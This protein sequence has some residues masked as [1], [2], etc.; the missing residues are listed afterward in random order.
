LRDGGFYT[1]WD[2]PLE[3]AE[4][5]VAAMD[6]AG[7]AVIE[8]GYRSP[9]SAGYAG[10]FKY[11]SEELARRLG[12][13][14]D[15]GFAVMV[16][17]KDFVGKEV[18]ISRLFAPADESRITMVR[19]ATRSEH[20]DSTN[21]LVN[22]LNELGYQ[23]TINLMAWALLDRDEQRRAVEGMASSKAD[24]IYIADSFGGMHPSD[25]AEAAEL[26]DTIGDKA[27][28]VHL[29]NNLEMAFANALAAVQHG[30]TWVDTSVL[31]M[32]RGPGNLKTELWLQHLAT[33]LADDRYQT[34]A[35]YE[36]IGQHLRPLQDQHRWGPG[37]AY[38]LSG[39]LGVHPSFAQRLLETGRY[40]VGEIIAV[41]DRLHQ[42]GRGASF[43]RDALDEAISQRHQRLRSASDAAHASSTDI[44]RLPQHDWSKR[45]A[46]IVGRG[47]LLHR[48]IDA[49]NEYIECN[50]PV[51]FECNFLPNVLLTDDHYCAFVLL[52]NARSMV[53]TARASD[54]QVV[55]GY[56]GSP[57]DLGRTM[58]APFVFSEPYETHSGTLSFED[59]CVIP[60]DVVS[61]FAIGLAVQRGIRRISVVG[62]D[63][64]T[65]SGTQRE[66]RMQ[67]E[68]EQFFSLLRDEYP[69][70]T[71]KSLLKTNYPIAQESI[72]ARIS[73]P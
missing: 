9:I 5:Y 63:G 55:L 7:V 66:Q 33:R 2:F 61:M 20:L 14:T 49:V 70:T 39:N 47:P 60:H 15:I 25:I 40:T 57:V 29:H 3:L 69:D 73:R 51:V 8:I 16:D 1:D 18:E 4:A 53:R 67:G 11:V 35:V 72:Y 68:M 36:F 21:E 38:V 27:W 48:H 12:A 10:P 64:Y 41:L 37:P 17:T 54:K 59:Q 65:S 43:S 34:D 24:V 6:A 23:T 58:D 28:G 42:S 71:V 30:A 13:N 50:R 52:A 62:F 45:E 44:R 31:G 19:V 32:G 46:L 22:L 26:M 56:A